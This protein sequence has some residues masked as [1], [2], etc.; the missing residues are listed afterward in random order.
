MP[1]STV[2]LASWAAP[3]RK[4]YIPSPLSPNDTMALENAMIIGL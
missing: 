2:G 4:D 1:G 3:V